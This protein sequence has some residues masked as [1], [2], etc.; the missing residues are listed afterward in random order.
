MGDVNRA[1]AV[2]VFAKKFD[3][4]RN[5]YCRSRGLSK[6]TSLLIPKAEMGKE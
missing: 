1:P 5:Q 6:V 4:R 3:A 2:R